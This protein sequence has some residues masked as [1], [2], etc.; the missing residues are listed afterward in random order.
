LEVPIIRL[1]LS[2]KE[3]KTMASNNKGIRISASNALKV[4]VE[5]GTPKQTVPLLKVTEGV[6]EKYGARDDAGTYR[7]RLYEKNDI[8]PVIR[9]YNA[10][11]H[12]VHRLITQPWEHGFGL[13][14][15]TGLT[16]YQD[17]HRQA[18]VR[19]Y[20]AVDDLRKDFD[21]ILARSE[22]RLGKM[23]EQVIWPT[24]DQ[25]ASEFY[26]R[27]VIREVDGT[28]DLRTTLTKEEVE[29]IEND[30]RTKL[31]E[32]NLSV[33]QRIAEALR[34]SARVQ[35]Q[36][37]KKKNSKLYESTTRSKLEDLLDAFDC[38]NINGIDG[39]PDKELDSIGKDITKMIGKCSFED[40]KGDENVRN[41]SITDT[42]R[43]AEKVEA[44]IKDIEDEIEELV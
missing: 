9:H 8:L 34:E 28:N 5:Q 7:V 2:K 41:K 1:T 15:R 44:K 25:W 35:S 17:E 6:H 19:Y 18:S 27:I 43:I 42:S 4:G 10:F 32:G 13:I 16:K 36:Y 14:A 33:Y 23:A 22:R 21:N 31:R 30:M 40:I 38:I 29:S 39:K 26:F 11:Y 3:T 24:V 20:D 37:K 12:K